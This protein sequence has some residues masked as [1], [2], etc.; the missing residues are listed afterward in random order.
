MPDPVFQAA[1][2]HEGGQ[3][4]LQLKQLTR[5]SAVINDK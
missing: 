2:T 1:N 5:F 3:A 4:K